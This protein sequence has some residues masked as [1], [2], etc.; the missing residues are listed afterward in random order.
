MKRYGL[1]SWGA[2]LKSPR[3]KLRPP[4][5]FAKSRAS[6]AASEIER[7]AQRPN[8]IRM[9]KRAAARKASRV[10]SIRSNSGRR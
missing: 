3:N 9:S 7:L 8:I 10:A 5:P 6:K 1:K 4:G 2:N